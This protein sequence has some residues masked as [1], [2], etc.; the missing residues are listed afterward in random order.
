MKD[1]PADQRD[2]LR[3]EYEAKLNAASDEHAAAMREHAEEIGALKARLTDAR[4]RNVALA[5]Q[6]GEER[7]SHNE[8]KGELLE[9]LL[10]AEKLRGYLD[11][12]RDMQPPKMV[13]AARQTQEFAREDFT[14][15]RRG[16]GE[17]ARKRFF[18]RGAP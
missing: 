8:T 2:D 9:A 12:L 13:E 6:I 15:V 18:E 17:P 7:A 11:A 5:K 4:E 14:V 16:Y 1:K 3:S 10:V